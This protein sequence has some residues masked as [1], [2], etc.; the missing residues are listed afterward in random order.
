MNAFAKVAIAA[1]LSSGLVVGCGGGSSSP[2]NTV[3]DNGGTGGGSNPN[4]GPTDPQNRTFT[5]APDNGGDRPDGTAQTETL[6]AF[7]AAITG[8]TIEFQEGTFDFDTTLTMS[9]KEGITIKGAGL[10]KTILNFE[11]SSTPEGFNLSHMEGITIED[12]TV[13][14]T[15]GFSIKI[16]D[17]DHVVI[18][19]TRTM[20][21]SADNMMNPDVPS[22]LDVSCDGSGAVNEGYTVN[23][24]PDSTQ[25][26]AFPL[27]SGSYVD[28]NGTTRTYVVDKTNGG[29]AIYPVLSQ[30]VILEN[31]IAI[32]ASDAGI[33]VGQS[34]DIQVYNS[35]ALFNVAGYE[36]ENSDRADVYDSVAHCNTAGF[37][38]FDLPG[39]SQYGD[40]TR[41]FNNYAGYNNQDNFAPGGIVGV[42]PRGVGLL[43][44][45]YDRV[46]FFGNIVEFNTTLGF[47]SASHELLEGK[48]EHPDLRMDLYPEGI[49]IHDNTFTTN[50][51][52]PEPPAASAFQCA[53]GTGP[54]LTVEAGT[55]VPC[56]PTGVNDSDPSLL[57][58]LVQ[59]KS[60]MAGDPY[61]GQGAHIIWDGFFDDTAYDCELDQTGD[62]GKDF[63]NIVDTSVSEDG[64]PSGKPDYGSSDFPKCRYNAYK[65][66]EDSD[67]NGASTRRHP[68]YWQCYPDAGDVGGN[69]FSVDSR[70]FMNFKGTDP[71][72]APS[73]D[74][75]EHDCPTLFGVQLK[76]L[77]AAFAEPYEPSAGG[78]APPTE[79]E[80]LEACENFSGNTP[81]YAALEFNCPKLSHYNLFANKAEPRGDFNGNGILYDLITPL[82]SDYSSK[83]RVL[84]LPENDAAQWVEGN[85]SAPNATIDFPPGTVIAKTFA[86]KDGVNE[87]IIETRLII[88][89]TRIEDDGSKEHFWEGLPYIWE[90]DGNGN[91]IDANIAIAGGTAAVSWNYAD[92]DPAVNKTY[93]GSTDSYSVPHPN[94]CGSCHN[95]D[96]RQPGDAP[97]GPKIRNMNRPI[98]FGNGAVN[99]LQNLCDT[100][101]LTGCPDD[102]G[103]DG[104]TL[105][106]AN[107]L[108]IPRFDVPGDA[109][110]VPD[111]QNNNPDDAAKHNI[112]TRARA[113]L[114]TNCAHC[115]NRKGLAG[116][117][118]VFLD[119]F[120]K[121]N[122]SDGVCK[123]PNTAGSASDGRSKDIVPGDS[124]DSILSF[125][126]HAEDL[127]IQMP[128]IARSV[129]HDEAVVLIDDWI[130]NVLTAAY[131]DGDCA[132]E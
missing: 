80:I 88:Y 69:T 28:E 107:A 19:N 100:G 9:H 10:K 87:E 122:L 3:V 132:T 75:D 50:G 117:T 98:D 115:H 52:L 101:R 105:I 74:I 104:S 43:Q 114:E 116:S 65:F 55:T 48:P 108:R 102:L 106:A 56:V 16:S 83:Y 86:F 64:R 24:N 124:S 17:S 112:E 59:I 38:V 127:S 125:R 94:Q 37:L 110:N 40:G 2:G 23:R 77:P 89:R 5:I 85:G 111:V 35:E 53:A 79:A 14:D 8:D 60:T 27:A 70:K 63:T 21:S 62:G 1:L 67:N 126:I 20:W 45:G 96:D 4:D 73:V 32:G 66:F 128:P 72:V 109:F 118:G 120:G 26:P 12:L 54:A 13:Y 22:T 39:L 7:F 91:R 71:A 113:W 31:V 49:H 129:A 130:N 44:L 11:D 57:P 99:Q 29:Y 61:A 123:T 103:V 131:D 42:V 33:Y 46:E 25:P 119:V 18:R 97:I 58:A 51:T 36:I 41:I 78:A 81:N 90:T 76:P 68:L 15:P 82:F 92:P 6:T 93:T 84:F 30:N 47:V 121:V 34:N 95:N